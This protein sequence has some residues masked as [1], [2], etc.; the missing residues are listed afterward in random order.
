MRFPLLSVCLATI[1]STTIAL[2]QNPVAYVYV[3]ED[4]VQTP[5]SPIYAYASSSS[6]KLTALKGSPFTKAEN[7]GLMLGTNGSH[8]IF[9][10]QGPNGGGGAPYNYLYSFNV[11]SDGVLGQQVS[12]INTGLYSGTD[13]GGT[14][15]EEARG[16]E[17]DHTGQYIYVYQCDNA[18]QTFKIAHTGALN[19]QNVTVY[20]NPSNISGGVPKIAGNNLY[21]Y[22]TTL[23]K[24]P[25]F[26]NTAG[27][28]LFAQES[29]G[30]LESRGQAAVTWPK[31]PTNYFAGFASDSPDFFLQH[32]IDPKVLLTNDQTNHFAAQLTLFKFTPPDTIANEGCAFASFTVGSSGGLTSTNTYDNMPQGNCGNQML[33]SPSGK[34]AVV[35]TYA[36]NLYFL[37]FN[38]SAPMTR[39]ASVINKSGGFATIAWDNAGHLYALNA[40]SGRLHVYTVTSTTV[41]EAPGS[42]YN[43]PFCGIDTDT[44][45]PECPQTLI[46]RSIPQ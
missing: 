45:G 12:V 42:P 37:H 41:V 44:G 16:A 17:L 35:N 23:A 1:T 5:Y 3:G 19:F 4:A 40:L 36:G 22:N 38:G 28:N 14:T 29:D 6:G 26:G 21:A 25:V 10:G 32:F 24:S 20:S 9:M 46:V 34:I 27:L 43:L 2:A 39:F 31:L 18:V 33:L 30:S 13:C 11:G 15:V 7:T 8:F